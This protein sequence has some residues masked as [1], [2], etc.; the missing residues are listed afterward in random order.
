VV[1]KDNGSLERIPLRQIAI[2]PSQLPAICSDPIE[3]MPEKVFPL[4][5]S[6]IDGQQVYALAAF[7]DHLWCIT[8]GGILRWMWGKTQHYT[9]FGSEHG[10]HGTRFDWMVVDGQGNPWVAGRTSGAGYWDGKTWQYLSAK[11]G[12]TS[13][14]IFCLAVDHSGKVWIVSDKGVGIVKHQ[15]GR[16][17]WEVIDI[18]SAGLPDYRI[19]CLGFDDQNRLILGTPWGLFLQTSN[20]TTWRRYTISDGLPCNQ[21]T[22]IHHLL[23]DEMLIGTSSG[24]ARVS[25]NGTTRINDIRHSVKS[26]VANPSNGELWI[27]TSRALW[28]LNGITL[29]KTVDP[30]FEKVGRI[31][32]IN[33]AN[34]TLWIGSE[35]GL[36]KH[37]KGFAY[38]RTPGIRDL[39]EGEITNLVI[40][41]QN[42][43]WV[44]NSKGLWV[45]GGREW[46]CYQ[47]NNQLIS[48]I[49]N[50]S[51]IQPT[52]DSSMW[53]GSWQKGHEGGMRLFRYGAEIPHQLFGGIETVDKIAIGCD[54]NLVIATGDLIVRQAGE[55]QKTLATPDPTCLVNCML[56]DHA[57]LLWCGMKSGLYVQIKDGWLQMKGQVQIYNLVEDVN[58]VIW[59]GTD[60]G[61][62]HVG[63][64][65]LIP[66]GVDL[67]SRQV[68]ALCLSETA[69]WVGTSIGLVRM[70]NRDCQTWNV[71]NSGLA[72]NSIYTLALE[73]NRVLWIGTNMGLS[74]LDI[75]TL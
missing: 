54:G 25:K 50:I 4:W 70:C 9:W 29:E 32:S 31:L 64:N 51:C 48:P 73:E 59:A 67:P 17:K 34:G 42:N 63:D 53:I 27:L 6:C 37:E 13:T 24:L 74:K 49:S 26:I 65:S 35:A 72:G 60:D 58:G 71:T 46:Q 1:N 10:L 21:V 55:I 68:Q 20:V 5:T 57:G 18:S 15:N 69:L 33:C 39:P 28:R 52:P 2:R 75:H 45:H 36:I 66:V 56:I 23:N 47:T 7:Q 19:S 62:F 44:G 41:P 38:I 11:N 30:L 61:L 16:Y 40:D 14:Q 12:F 3:D 8:S 43:I 22:A